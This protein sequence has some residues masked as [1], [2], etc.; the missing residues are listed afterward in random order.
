MEE[1]EKKE[2]PHLKRAP[3]YKSLERKQKLDELEREASTLAILKHR[4]K[5]INFDKQSQHQKKIE[6]IIEKRKAENPL[7]GRFGLSTLLYLS[8][9]II[10]DDFFDLRKIS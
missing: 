9:W 10:P 4:N 7:K 1:W 6:E 5:P 3:L 8:K 2:C